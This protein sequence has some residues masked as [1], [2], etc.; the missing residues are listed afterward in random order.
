MGG[1][2]CYQREE[3]IIFYCGTGYI[4][5]NMDKN[6]E[7]GHTHLK[8]FNAGKRAINLVMKKKIPRDTGNYFLESLARLSDDPKYSEDCRQLIETRKEK[9]KKISYRNETKAQR[10]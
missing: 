9:G 6:F 2:K 7:E 3:F 10:R 1:N 5:Q 4:V 8:N